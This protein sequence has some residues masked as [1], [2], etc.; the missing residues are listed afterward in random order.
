VLRWCGLDQCCCSYSHVQSIVS[1]VKVVRFIYNTLNLRGTS[2]DI[3]IHYA[4][5]FLEEYFFFTEHLNQC[6]I[7]NMLTLVSM[8]TKKDTTPQSIALQAG[9]VRFPMVSL[10]FFIDIILPTALWP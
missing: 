4:T 5:F 9:R 7:W 10:E 2:N 3:V 1:T 8:G 6:A